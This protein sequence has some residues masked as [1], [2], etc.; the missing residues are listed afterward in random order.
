M[1]KDLFINLSKAAIE[2]VKC[3]SPRSCHRFLDLK[4]KLTNKQRAVGW[5]QLMSAFPS[6]QATDI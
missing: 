5:S 6:I 4:L 3:C 1:C 2:K